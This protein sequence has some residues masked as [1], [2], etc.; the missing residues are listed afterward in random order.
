VGDQGRRET[1]ACGKSRQEKGSGPFSH[2]KKKGPD[3]L[4]LGAE[5]SDFEG[6]S[7]P[8]GDVDLRRCVEAEPLDGLEEVEAA[9][10]LLFVE[11]GGVELLPRGAG[12]RASVGDG[13]ERLGEERVEGAEL[14][15][16]VRRVARPPAL[17]NPAEVLALEPDQGEGFVE[18]VG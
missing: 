3:P 4:F 2:A 18:G 1:P 13:V 14:V 12:E 9:L 10:E 17:G 7:P 8:Y 15:R 11:L 16:N 6:R 5:R